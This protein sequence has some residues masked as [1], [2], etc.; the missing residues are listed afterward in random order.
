MLE[1]EFYWMTTQQNQSVVWKGDILLFDWIANI[2]FGLEFQHVSSGGAVIPDSSTEYR[3]YDRVV[4]IRQ[5]YAVPFGLRGT[6][7]GIHPAEVEVNT[8]YEVVFDESFMGGI[9]IR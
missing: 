7:V 4:N 9:S 6:V 3:L 1:Y 2:K 5:G 8:V